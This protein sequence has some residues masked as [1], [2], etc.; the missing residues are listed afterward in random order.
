IVIPR[1][2]PL[3]AEISKEFV[4][5]EPSQQGVHVNVFRGEYKDVNLC[6]PIG[7]F[8]LLGLPSGRP[9]GCKVRVTFAINSSG[10]IEVNALD[11]ETGTNTHTVINYRVEQTVEEISFK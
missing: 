11:L 10:V 2:T 8:L 3:P 6:T 1:N 4:T 5:T 7:E 9:A